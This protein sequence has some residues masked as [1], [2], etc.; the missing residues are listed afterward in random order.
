MK[1][2]V[3]KIGEKWIVKVGER[4]I[5]C[6][7]PTDAEDK[8]PPTDAQANDI[9]KARTDD[10]ALRT[11]VDVNFKVPFFYQESSDFEAT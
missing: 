9:I 8:P 7:A 11:T 4:L 1:G 2:V 10:G 3:P 6:A 5:W